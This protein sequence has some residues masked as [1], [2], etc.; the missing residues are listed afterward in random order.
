M[1]LSVNDF[2]TS[3]KQPLMNR[4]KQHVGEFLSFLFTPG[5]SL[6]AGCVTLIICYFVCSLYQSLFLKK[7]APCLFLKTVLMSK[8]ATIK[9]C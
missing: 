8:G 6:N 4:H 2:V 9:C 5:S 3:A 1:Q 7:T